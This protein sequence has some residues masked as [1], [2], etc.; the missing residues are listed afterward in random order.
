MNNIYDQ[1]SAIEW[2]KS[3]GKESI[4]VDHATWCAIRKHCYSD[5][6][7]AGVLVEYIYNKQQMR[8]FFGDGPGVLITRAGT[9]PRPSE[10]FPPTEVVLLNGPSKEP[11][12]G[13]SIFRSLA[14]WYMKLKAIKRALGE[15]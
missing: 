11:V 8:V 13:P 9:P 2:I 7:G 15:S 14:P 3:Q 12:Y 10:P 1:S 4:E 5:D 6:F